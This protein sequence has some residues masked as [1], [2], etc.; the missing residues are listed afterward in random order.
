VLP[1]ISVTVER[2]GK[3]RLGMSMFSASALKIAGGILASGLVLG[4]A[5]VAAVQG[6]HINDNS[7][8]AAHAGK[9]EAG[10]SAGA[11]ASKSTVGG[12]ASEGA[13]ASAAGASVPPGVSESGQASVPTVNPSVPTVNPSVPTVNPSVPTVNPTG[14]LSA[15]YHGTYSL[16]VPGIPG[17]KKTFCLSGTVAN[18]CQ[19]VVVPTTGAMILTLSY[20]SNAGQTP[21]VFTPGLCTGGLSIGLAGMTPGATV[22]ASVS[23]QSTATSASESVPSKAE[24]ETASVCD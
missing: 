22:S 24:T 8:G 2:G 14:L 11:S 7:G 21:P 6:V 20:S 4:G 9:N 23:G 13:S 17:A 18:E 16:A 3:E 15:Y 12:S 1:K 10:A 19:V 5:T